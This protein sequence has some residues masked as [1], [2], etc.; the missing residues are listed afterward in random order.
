M[1]VIMQVGMIAH[2]LCYRAMLQKVFFF[3]KLHTIILIVKVLIGCVCVGPS[4]VANIIE[5]FCFK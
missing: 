1:S 4:K 2:L 5:P 3:S